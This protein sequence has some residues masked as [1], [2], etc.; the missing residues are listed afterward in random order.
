MTWSS[1][2]A[3]ARFSGDSDSRFLQSELV[4]GV[5]LVLIGVISGG[6]GGAI[7]WLS[8][9]PN[10]ATLGQAITGGALLG[11]LAIGSLLGGA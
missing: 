4:G 3:L 1:A 10:V 5:L 7:W 9:G 6:S 2:A 8:V 11:A